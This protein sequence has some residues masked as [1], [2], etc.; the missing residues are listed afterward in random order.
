MF[1]D[2]MQLMSVIDFKKLLSS[3]KNAFEGLKTAS[4][5]QSFRIQLVM[6]ALVVVLMFFFPLRYLE[7][8]ILILAISFVL[9]LEL[10]NSQLERALDL[11]ETN[12]NP[13]IK[14]IKDLSAAAVLI[15]SLGAAL[16]G[17]FIFFSYL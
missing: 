8:T 6:A 10:L 7:K 13:K 2:I 5:E 12:H 1:G 15:A 4:S 11:I 3:F 9:G 16:A 14:A 17:F